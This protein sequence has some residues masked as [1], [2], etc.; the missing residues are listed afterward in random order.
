[1]EL[2][3]SEINEAKIYWIKSVQASNFKAEL[4]FLTKN[5]Q[6]S[7][8]LRVKQFGLYKDDKDVLRCKGRLTNADLPTTRKNPILLQSKK[9]FVTL[10][11][12]DAHAKVKHRPL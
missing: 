3:A 6:M 2:S 11:I 7:P 12:K 1:M 8:L 9:D 10:L 4:N 5:S